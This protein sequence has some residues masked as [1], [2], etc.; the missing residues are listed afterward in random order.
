MTDIQVRRTKIVATL[1]PATDAPGMLERILEEGV[2]VVRLNL[3][4]G[5]PDDHRARAAAV[6]AAAEAV[7]REVGILADLQGP[8]IRIEKFAGGPVDLMAGDSFVLDCRP[9]APAGNASRIGVSYYGLPNDVVAGDV[10]LLDDGLVAMTVVEVVGSEVR[11]RVA[12][13]GRLSDRK[14]LNR[15]GG[16]LSVAALSDKDRAD[17]KLAAEMGADFLAVSF[18]RCAEDLHEARRLLREAGGDAAIVSKIER[19]D[20]IPVLGEIIDASDVVMVARGDL[21]VEIGDAELPGLQKKIIRESVLRN[22][23][24]ITATQMLQSMVTAPIPT[25]A[26]VLD[27]ANAVID[28]TDA[29]MLSQE[30]AA[31]A[32]PDKAVAAMRRICLGAERQFEPRDDL[33]PGIHQLDR[34]DQAIALAAMLL[35]A[36]VGVRAIVALTESGATAQW[37]S[38][39]R[40]AVPIYALSPSDVARRRMLVLRDVQ[41][42]DFEQSNLDPA[43]TARAAL[44]H[45][46]QLGKLAE[47]D[48]VILTHGDHI[49]RGG[50]TNT[51]KLL[52][53]G[54]DGIPDSLRDL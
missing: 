44:Q 31:G 40:F 35:A 13:G 39:Y 42:V 26:E 27:V 19:A 47:G 49:G 48:R 6:R 53:I 24:V 16:G 14:G 23:S 22:R 45:L 30:S 33:R 7:G 3:S 43:H 38:R 25:R 34:S 18:V 54:N 11:C 2:D 52:V 41:P 51:L 28:G 9:D 29:V 4:H 21:G 12:I 15:Q 36:Q 1:G 8:K 17:I 37:L 46:F 50:G 10:L 5:T 32:H 20:A